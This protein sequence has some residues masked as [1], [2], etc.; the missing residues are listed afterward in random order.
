[1]PEQAEDTY[2]KVLPPMSCETA[3]RYFRKTG[4]GSNAL[5]RAP[6]VVG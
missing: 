2:L 4:V 3:L 1:M 5:D 6:A